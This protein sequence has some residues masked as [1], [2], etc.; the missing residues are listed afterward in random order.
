VI[1]EHSRFDPAGP[2]VP[3]IAEHALVSPIASGA[4]GQVW[5]ARSALGT[6][7][8]IK[9]VHRSNF[10]HDRPFERE[11]AGIQKYE[12]VSRSHEG[13]VDL[14]QVGRNDPQGYFYYVM[15]LAD[16]ANAECGLRT[17]ESGDPTLSSI[18]YSALRAPRSY[19][20]KTLKQV[21]QA[22][23]HLSYEEC[24][25][26]GLSLSSAL[27]YLHDQSLVHRDIKPSN[28]IFV[29]GV[30][31]LA[32]VG[33]VTNV[34]ETRS[35]VGTE[36]F[37][38]PE[39][40]GTPRADIYSL[41]IVLY[42]MS[43][44]KSHQD[45]PEPLNELATEPDHAQWLEF[46]EVIHKACRAEVHERYQSAEQMHQEL[47]LLQ[48]G[49]SVK[50]E[51][52]A[53]K[54]R[55][56]VQKLALVTFFLACLLLALRFTGTPALRHR[57]NPEAMRLYELGRWHYNQ[58]TTE[59]HDKALNYLTQAV[60]IDPTFAQPYGE[61]AALYTW[62][63]L[64]GVDS[65]QERHRRTQEIA[66]KALAINPDQAEGHAALSWTRFLERDWH[67]AETEVGRA[68][69][70]NPDLAIAHNMYCFYL[71]LLGR[72]AEAR[73]EGQRAEQLEP[74]G[75]KRV[76]ALIAAFPLMAE[77]RHDEVIRQLR[78]VLELDK[79]F[80]Y[81]HCFLA[82]CY[83]AKSNYVA[84]IEEFRIFCQ[85]TSQDPVRVATS[86]DA[87]RQAY[88]SSGQAGYFRKWIELVLADQALPED[89]QM[90]GEMDL[91]G[92]YALAGEKEQAL[93]YLEKHFDDPNVWQQMKF[94]WQYDSLHH[95]PRFEALVKRTRLED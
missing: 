4:Y 61:M 65:E 38:A 75:S 86:Y 80:A 66:E 51:R 72:T 84:A 49:K 10:D 44:G 94:K 54:R 2:G 25:R 69:K 16:D 6:Y 18:P 81:G 59:D 79:N 28:V 89:K 8:A 17:S 73:R 11:F 52:A 93:D 12:P 46:N 40:P 22:R 48:A 34:G 57:P 43:T 27:A 23:G 35:Y 36:G 15:E 19:V 90:F 14:L 82:E 1:A 58:L 76:T 62:N 30:P 37:I 7:R 95:E 60:R 67:G 21:I 42:V 53:R 85:F 31:K 24:I 78:G 45:F 64:S 39:G 70:S 55:G 77:R 88:E 9:L 13:L 29:E 74:P 26:V 71:T 3:L 41:G 47:A 32:D 5:L 83:E 50:R 33:L 56:M 63:I 91:G 20:P 68:L 87:L 92:Y